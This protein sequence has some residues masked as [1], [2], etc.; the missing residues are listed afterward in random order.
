MEGWECR[1]L[2]R[3]SYASVQES[4]YQGSTFVLSRDGDLAQLRSPTVSQ[5]EPLNSPPYL[6]AGTSEA[7]RL[8]QGFE[9]QAAGCGHPDRL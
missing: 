6:E 9:P 3:C 5:L 7:F 2:G 8:Q 4:G 1:G